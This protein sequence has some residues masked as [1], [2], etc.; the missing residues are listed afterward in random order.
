[1]ISLLIA[2][3]EQDTREALRDMIHWQQAGIVLLDVVGDGQSALECM[4]RKRPTVALLDIRMPLLDGLAVAKAA[5]A[6]GLPT[7]ILFLS[8]YDEFSYAQQ[9][10]KYGAKDYLLKPCKPETIL[11]SVLRAAGGASAPPQP[12][13]PKTGSPVINAALRY[14]DEH[15]AE[16]LDLTTVAQAVYITPAYLSLAF[17]QQTKTNFVEYLNQRRIEKAC[18]LL[19]HMDL[20]TYEVAQRVGYQDEKYFSRVFKKLK[21]VNPSQYRRKL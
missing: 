12:E 8:G 10:I 5:M 13:P 2:E 16:P 7:R 19:S 3:D 6:E 20:K 4:R 11:E 15:Y 17:K 14:I 9:G 21:G 18:E 1:M